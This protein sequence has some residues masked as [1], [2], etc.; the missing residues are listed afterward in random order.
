MTL[1]LIPLVDRQE[2]NDECISLLNEE[3]PRS[4]TSRAHSQQK[5]CR[6]SPPMSLLLIEE[7][8]LIGHARICLLPDRRDAC[9]A[10]SVII[11]KSHRGRGLG[12]ILM[13]MVESRAVEM[14]F[15]KV[16]L[17]THDQVPFYRSC[18]YEICAPILHS[19]TA[20]S[21]FPVLAKLAPP[22]PA[23][24]STISPRINGTL[25]SSTTVSPP[26][27]PP[28][29]PKASATKCKEDDDCIE[30][31]CKTIG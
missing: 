28:P 27:P 4:Y 25:P 5:S 22:P 7:S 2:L 11:R 17:S 8:E 1:S 15:S 3:W 21:V 12:K 16:Y 30:Y 23:T 10:E 24:K 29:V 9:W 13:N 26:P 14:S 20:T 18:G 19:T 6:A 31:M